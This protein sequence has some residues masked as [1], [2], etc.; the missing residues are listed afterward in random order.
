ME[1]LSRNFRPDFLNRVDDTVMFRP[2]KK[3]EIIKIIDIV[4]KDIQKRLDDR[5]ITLDVSGE[6]KLLIA[7]KSYTPIYGARPV[8]RYLQ[9]NFETELGKLIIKG[10]LEDGQKVIVSVKNDKLEFESVNN[11]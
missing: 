6:A 8:K 9:K 1:E 11:I 10:D 7:D 2:L 3:D 5:N 4:L